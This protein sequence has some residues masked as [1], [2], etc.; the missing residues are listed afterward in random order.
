VSIV[1]SAS[2]VVVLQFD[3]EAALRRHMVRQV[4]GKLAATS[5]N[6]NIK[7]RH[8]LVVSLQNQKL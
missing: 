7:L 3:A 1:N 4:T 8:C 5:S 2:S 6:R